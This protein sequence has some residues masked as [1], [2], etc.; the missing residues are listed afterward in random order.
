ML[1]KTTEMPTKIGSSGRAVTSFSQDHRI[2][3]AA[4]GQSVALWQMAAKPAEGRS[5][6]RRVAKPATTESTKR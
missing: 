1:E 2:G 6:A 3:F 4:L 5:G